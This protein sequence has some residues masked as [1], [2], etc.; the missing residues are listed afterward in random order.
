MNAA[1]VHPG[2]MQIFKR[3]LL[4][5]EQGIQRCKVRTAGVAQGEKIASRGLEV[6]TESCGFNDTSLYRGIAFDVTIEIRPFISRFRQS[7]RAKD[8]KSTFLHNLRN[9][10]S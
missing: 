3:W 2:F 5:P 4:V 1:S 6:D 10:S 7:W 9:A 8:K